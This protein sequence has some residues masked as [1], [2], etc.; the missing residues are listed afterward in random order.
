[1]LGVQ[2]SNNDGRHCC[3]SYAR[4]TQHVVSLSTS[5]SKVE[6]IAAGDGVKEALFVCAILSFITP[7]TSGASIKVL[8]N[9]Q[10]AK[11]LIENS[12]R[13]DRSKYIDV[14][15]HFI[16][17]LF[18][19]R[20][21]SEGYV[22]SAGQHADIRTKALSRASLQYHRKRWMNISEQSTLALG[23]LFQAANVPARHSRQVGSE[24]S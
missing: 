18:R 19:T 16:R 13:S 22:A 8:E 3:K 15:F 6:Y 9:N 10:G 1:M 11:A 24:L 5:T 12:L 7:E 23:K 21:I 4:K 17:D 2:D 20:K 14:R